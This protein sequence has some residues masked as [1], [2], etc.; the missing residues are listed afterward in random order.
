MIADIGGTNARFAA[1]PKRT[2]EAGIPV[3]LPTRAHPDFGDALDLVLGRLGDR[4]GL[5]RIVPAVAAPAGK[6]PVKLTNADWVID[7]DAA[8]RRYNLAAV[9]IINDFNAIA[10]ALPHLSGGDLLSLQ[11]GQAD[12]NGALAVIG[13][14]TGLGVSGLVP[15]PGGT[16]LPIAGE[17]GH[18]T[19]APET[20]TA[21]R[22]AQALRNTHGRT[23]SERVI[24]GQGLVDV[25]AILG[26]RAEIMTPHQVV[27]AAR[28]SGTCPACREAVT[29][30]LR[31]L[32]RA[33]GDLALTL[34]ATAGVFIG[35]G[36]SRRL[37]SFPP[38]R[39][40]PRQ[41]KKHEPN[42]PHPP[43]DHHGRQSR[44]D[45]PGGACPYKG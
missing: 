12:P 27:D 18:A 41:G 25:A 42:G 22:I 17:G 15:V 5:A 44:P 28:S 24:S 43:C 3:I 9:E 35:G 8:R 36:T 37:G 6:W 21:W 1:V 13:P 33:A 4:D 14:G 39:R 45:R 30:F 19:Y 32:G 20:E 40:L 7:A 2:G 26:A 10:L 34:G 11:T 31:G 29:V 23:S 38:C 16:W